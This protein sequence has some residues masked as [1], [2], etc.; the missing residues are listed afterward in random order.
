[1]KILEMFKAVREVKADV[2]K[3]LT[4]LQSDE[5]MLRRERDVLIAQPAAKSDIKAMVGAWFDRQGTGYR[6]QLQQSLQYFILRPSH[7]AG[8][9]SDLKLSI[10]GPAM[11]SGN[12]A[13]TASELDQLLVALLGPTLRPALLAMVDAMTFEEGLP[14]QERSQRVAEIDARIAKIRAEIKELVSHA[15]AAGI[16]LD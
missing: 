15:E 8:P 12:A 2:D 3:R 9:T 6:D 7:I 14:M 1:M 11:Q 4:K 5:E 13:P 10:S 16:S